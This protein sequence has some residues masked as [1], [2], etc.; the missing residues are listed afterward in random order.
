M[1]QLH[2]LEPIASRLNAFAEP[3]TPPSQNFKHRLSDSS[4]LVVRLSVLQK[5]QIR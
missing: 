4:P 1:I 3:P 2:S 5:C